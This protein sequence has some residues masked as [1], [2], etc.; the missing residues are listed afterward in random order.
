MSGLYPAPD[1]VQELLA[2]REGVQQ[3][4]LDVGCG[5]GA[6]AISMA[7][8]FP[9]AHVVGIDLAPV[10]ISDTLPSNVTFELDDVNKGLTHL[11]DTFHLVHVR[12]VATGLRDFSK[13]KAEIE[14][15]LKPGG[16]AIWIDADYDMLSRDK[17]IYR[18]PAI[19]GSVED[20]SWVARMFFE[21]RRIAVQLGG[22]SLFA[23][24]ES[25]SRGLWDDELLDPNTCARADLFLPIGPWVTDKDP[26]QSQRLS[27][28]GSLMRQDFMSGYR[29]FHPALQRVGI[30]PETCEQWSNRADEELNTMK[31]PI[32]VRIACAWGRRRT[33][34]NGPAPPLPSS[35][36]DSTS[37]R[38]DAAPPSSSSHSTASP[39]LPPYPYME[40]HTTK[41]A[42][43]EAYER[44]NRSKTFAVPPLPPGLQL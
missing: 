29:A 27:H 25:L 39:V 34:L 16:L 36:A 17:D 19:E 8:E 23:V 7:K 10:P 22:S 24:T 41:S 26:V 43:L 18:P 4:I 32:F 40:I 11:Y 20:G 44:R 3:R 14:R 35:N 2:P 12:F 15:C 31:D 37:S 28:I 42:A 33:S 5:T 9:H 30:P 1:I 6:W 21:T 13:C 38:L